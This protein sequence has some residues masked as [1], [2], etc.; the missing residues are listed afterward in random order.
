LK[1]NQLMRRVW[2]FW[3]SL[4]KPRRA[5][6]IRGTVIRVMNDAKLVYEETPPSS[7]FR[8]RSQG[9]SC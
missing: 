1:M 4:P 7:A 5:C 2:G 6:A 9:E 8:I 3:R